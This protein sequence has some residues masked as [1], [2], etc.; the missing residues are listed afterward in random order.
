MTTASDIKP[1][2]RLVLHE[3]LPF[4]SPTGGGV[5]RRSDLIE[6]T[7][8]SHGQAQWRLV[9][10]LS[11]SGAPAEGSRAASETGGF[12]VEFLDELIE[13]GLYAWA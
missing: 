4:S 11:E 9:E 3:T 10:V 1:G 2:A 6:V 7:S 5:H 13:A 8:V 12:V